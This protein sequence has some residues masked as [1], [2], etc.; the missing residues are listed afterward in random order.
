MTSMRYSFWY[1]LLVHCSSLILT[2]SYKLLKK[3]LI[4]HYRYFDFVF[5]G[6]FLH[7]LIKVVLYLITG[8][9]LASSFNL[10]LL[11]LSIYICTLVDIYYY[12]HYTIH[13][14]LKYVFYYLENT[15]HEEYIYSPEHDFY[16]K[17]TRFKIKYEKAKISENYNF[18]RD[19][20]HFFKYFFSFFIA[21]RYFIIREPYIFSVIHLLVFINY[22]QDYNVSLLF[23]YLFIIQMSRLIF[24]MGPNVERFRFTTWNKTFIQ[25]LAQIPSASDSLSYQCMTVPSLRYLKCNLDIDSELLL[26]FTKNNINLIMYFTFRR[27]ITPEA[28]DDPVEYYHKLSRLYD[29]VDYGVGFNKLNYSIEN[30][31][32]ISNNIPELYGHISNLIIDSQRFVKKNQGF[33]LATFIFYIYFEYTFVSALIMANTTKSS[34]QYAPYTI[35]PVKRAIP[36]WLFALE[37]S[38]SEPWSQAELDHLIG[39]IFYG[40]AFYM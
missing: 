5:S 9:Q 14:S 19:R 10:I 1:G 4:I 12:I 37:H 11:L 22:L 30:S 15:L 35:N 8:M 38:I 24:F 34:L 39:L 3:N 6:F 25:V 18:E 16:R 7:L 2:K 31:Y 32:F 20:F 26:K 33:W 13:L 28:G 29:E 23:T 21:V 36:N 17:M 40:M 27:Q